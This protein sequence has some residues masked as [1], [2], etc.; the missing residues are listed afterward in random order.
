M[1]DLADKKA[2]QLATLL[3]NRFGDTFAPI[4]DTEPAQLD[5]L[6][7]M[8]QHSSARRFSSQEVGPE[9]LQTLL[10]CA[11]SAPSKSD[12][13]QADI[14]HVTDTE[15]RAQIVANIPDMPWINKAPVFLV[16]CGNNRRARLLGAWRNKPFA[17]EH[18][19]HFMNAAVDAGIMMI[20]FIRAAES[21]GLSTCPISGIRNAIVQNSALL[22]LPEGVFPLAGLCLG[23]PLQAGQITARLPLTA[24][25]HKNRYSE[26]SLKTH[27]DAYDHRRHQMQ[28]YR[29]QRNPEQFGEVEFY[30]WSE[31]KAR[32]Y[33]V[34]ERTDFGQF[35]RN[36]GFSLK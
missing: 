13:Q 10:G 31:D 3:E 26:D 6:I 17:N 19:D 32:Q 22:G 7:S 34:P 23:Y 29:Q 9:L 28:P 2:R 1:K 33:A 16:F 11:M 4:K 35:I 25:V 36:H 27:I 20:N 18:L 5:Q 12:L 14:I 21:V 15:L 8:A 30:G 24:T